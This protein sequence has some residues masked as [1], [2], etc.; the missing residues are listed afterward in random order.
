MENL[1]KNRLL[2]IVE[3]EGLTPSRPLQNYIQAELN[4]WICSN[5]YKNDK[6]YFYHIIFSR[7]QKTLRITCFT[8]LYTKNNRCVESFSEG[9][10]TKS[11]FINCLQDLRE[12]EI[13]YLSRSLRRRQTKHPITV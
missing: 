5:L 6:P 11:T 9:D 4:N 10:T 3:F 8:T 2:G 7:C 13:I 12:N 1:K